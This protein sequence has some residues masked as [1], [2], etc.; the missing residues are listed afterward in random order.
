MKKQV[1]LGLV[2]ATLFAGNVF[3]QDNWLS[4][5]IGLIGV[6][7]Q[8]ERTLTPNWGVGGGAFWSFYPDIINDWD[9]VND[10]FVQAFFRWYPWARTFYAKIGLGYNMHL[11]SDTSIN[12]FF[13]EPG[14]GW[15][16]DVGKEGGFFIE[17]SVALPVRLGVNSSNKEF[18][19][20]FGFIA[21]IAFG[22]TL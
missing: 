14:I 11:E 2:L 1:M 13:V 5:S 7:V 8:Y 18:E 4:G 17:P 22:C 9:I 15:K 10:V 21:Q 3:G 20:G 16:I 12:G 6:G 19:Y